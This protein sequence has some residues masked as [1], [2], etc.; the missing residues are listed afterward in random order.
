MIA[1]R[2]LFKIT[3]RS[4]AALPTL[5]TCLQSK[6]REVNFLAV[7]AMEEMGP[8]A[9]PA[10]RALKEVQTHSLELRECARRALARIGD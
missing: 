3:G 2:A 5:I 6:D 8:A 7:V 4:N 10:I 9:R 1:A